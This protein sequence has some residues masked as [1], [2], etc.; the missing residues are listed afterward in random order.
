MVETLSRFGVPHSGGQL[1]MLQPKVKYRF[2]VVVVDFGTGIQQGDL[3]RQTISVSK[4]TL[5]HNAVEV[6]SYNSTA[7]Y[8]GKHSWDEIS[9]VLRDD[10]SN[11]ASYLVGSQI[12]KQLN[13]FEQTG[14][15]A[16]INYKFS[17]FI[18]TLDGGNT[19]DTPGTRGIPGVASGI[20][21]RWTLEG[22][23]LTNIK[24]SDLDYSSSDPQTIDLSI[25]YDNATYSGIAEQQI[26]MPSG[27]ANL[28]SLGG[29]PSSALGRGANL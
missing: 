5:K 20:L 29:R 9:L 22:C 7:Y 3:T 8:A 28:E 17:M 18:D 21:E 24:Y 14:F 4:P 23:F 10:I 1:G 2:R 26:L 6:H 12:Q 27:D 13:H 19:I 11:R 25:R 15:S 16:A